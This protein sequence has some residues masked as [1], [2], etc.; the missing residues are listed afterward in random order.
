MARGSFLSSQTSRKEKESPATSAA[1]AAAAAVAHQNKRIDRLSVNAIHGDR[2]SKGLRHFSLRVCQ[3][4][5][6][7]RAFFFQFIY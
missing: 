5:F 1:A 7:S 4:V 6:T 2:G 3:K